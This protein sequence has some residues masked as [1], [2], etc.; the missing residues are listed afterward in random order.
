VLVEAL[1]RGSGVQV[2]A[3]QLAAAQREHGVVQLRG[4]HGLVENGR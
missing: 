2:Q 4:R 1:L 3:E